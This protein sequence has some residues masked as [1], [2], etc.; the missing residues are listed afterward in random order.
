VNVFTGEEIVVPENGR[1]PLA[2]MFAGFPVAMMKVANS[3][4][5]IP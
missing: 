5:E 4:R 3:Y 1:I 2:Q